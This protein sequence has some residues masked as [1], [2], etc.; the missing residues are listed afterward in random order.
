[1]PANSPEEPPMTVDFLLVLGLDHENHLHGN[2]VVGIVL[3]WD[4]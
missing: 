1:M 4:H 2:K 3:M